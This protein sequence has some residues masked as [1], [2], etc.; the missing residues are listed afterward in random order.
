MEERPPPSCA[1]HLVFMNA[2]IML[3]C[4]RY[5]VPEIS[6]IAIPGTELGAVGLGQSLINCIH[7]RPVPHIYADVDAQADAYSF[8]QVQS[9]CSVMGH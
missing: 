6:D 4:K 3:V 2:F 9:L 5:I 7:I 8:E 1:E